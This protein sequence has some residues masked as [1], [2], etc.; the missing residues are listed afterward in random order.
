MT[1]RHLKTFILDACIYTVLDTLLLGFYE[2]DQNNTMNHFEVEGRGIIFLTDYSKKHN[3][4][5]SA[6]DLKNI[7]QKTFMCV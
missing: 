5:V 7:S 1:S 6:Q 4:Q 2:T 3:W